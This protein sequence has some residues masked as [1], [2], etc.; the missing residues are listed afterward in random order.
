MK[1][2]MNVEMEKLLAGI[3]SNPIG[4]FFILIRNKFNKILPGRSKNYYTK[5]QIRLI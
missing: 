4:L 2:T 3:V 5:G 1:L